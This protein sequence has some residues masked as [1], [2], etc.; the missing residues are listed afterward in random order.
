MYNV[1]YVLRLPAKPDVAW[2][3][4]SCSKRICIFLNHYIFHRWH[5]LIHM[6]IVVYAV[7][8]VH[9][10]VFRNINIMMTL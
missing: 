1:Y 7:I 3:V 5:T 6:Y 2:F 9:L 10:A 8:Q 4:M